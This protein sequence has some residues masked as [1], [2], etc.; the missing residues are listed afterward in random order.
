MHIELTLVDLGP[1][2]NHS[3]VLIILLK[4]TS[5]TKG[6][7]QLL[8]TSQLSGLYLYI[9]RRRGFEPWES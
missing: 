6:A 3:A 4:K 5:G 1:A 9:I 8:R 2:G 7:R